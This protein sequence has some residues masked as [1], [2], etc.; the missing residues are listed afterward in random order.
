MYNN[1]NIF[2]IKHFSIVCYCMLQSVYK[3]KQTFI[4]VGY[5]RYAIIMLDVTCDKWV[6]IFAIVV[7]TMRYEIMEHVQHMGAVCRFLQYTKRALLLF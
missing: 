7:N 2:S 5:F 6:R 1:Y 4:K 3:V